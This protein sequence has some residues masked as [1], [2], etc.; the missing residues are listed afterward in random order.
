MF[1]LDGVLCDVRHRLHHVANRPKDWDAFFNSAPAD[2][3]LGPGVA[4]VRQAIAAGFTVVYLTGR[5]QRCRDDTRA[6]L[7]EQGLPTS[8]LHMR[9]P[10]DRRPARLPKVE[11]LAE[12]DTRY[13]LRVYVDDDAAVVAAARA[14]GYPV[15]HATWMDATTSGVDGA[16]SDA[17]VLLGEIQEG[18][19]RT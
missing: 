4:A 12:L 2:P 7:A 9:R 18:E 1:D 13:C 10:H 6:W 15:T 17:R 19:G 16:P 5:P 11:K 3:P 8:P 14:A